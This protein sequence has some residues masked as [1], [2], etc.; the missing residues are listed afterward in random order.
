[1]AK[2][3]IGFFGRRA[4]QEEMRRNEM[5][6]RT[7]YMNYRADMMKKTVEQIEKFEESLETKM[8]SFRS[9]PDEFYS[10]GIKQGPLAGYQY[11]ND[12]GSARRKSRTVE[13]ES[14]IAQSFARRIATLSVG[15]GLELESQPY[16]DLM[17]LSAEWTD[18]KKAEW[19]KRTE[20]RYALWAKNKKVSY[21]ES[22]NRYQ[23]EQQEFYD[24]LVDGEYFEVYRYSNVTK[25]NPM[26]IQIIRPEDVRTPMGSI[27]ATGNTEEQGIEYNPQGIAVA[28]HIYNEAAQKTVRVLRKGER[29]GRVIVNHVKLGKNRRGIGILANMI[30][31]LM[32]MGDFEVLELQAAVV[33]AL[34]AVWFKTPVGEMPMPDLG[35]G[36]TKAG[37]DATPESSMAFDTEAATGWMNKA[38]E[39]DYSGG[40]LMLD[41]LPGGV[42]PSSF[43]TKRPNVNFGTFMDQVKKNIAASRGISVSVLDGIFGQSYSASRG[44]LI[45]TWYEINRYRYNQSI[46]N[47]IVLEMWLWGEITRGKIEAPGFMEDEEIRAAWC[48]AHWIGN[49]RPDIDP[50]KSVQAHMYEQNRGYNTGKAIAAERNGSDYDENLVRCK[51]ELERVAEMQIPFQALDVNLNDQ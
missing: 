44:E 41:M 43:D 48:N 37:G 3:R 34:Y 17:Q 9:L 32:K 24:L 38:K 27:I 39:M 45:L 51:K 40:G 21:D 18:D 19:T 47:D 20:N 6:A 5:D 36:I 10:S 8:R 46:T 50:L 1:M 2:D 25:R 49:P 12:N 11:A 23:Q 26:T 15:M 7:R 31:E 16:W 22:M 42:E 30:S 33:N 29:S 28:Y 14:P 35:S 4:R 13:N